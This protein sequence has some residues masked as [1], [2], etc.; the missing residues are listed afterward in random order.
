[1]EPGVGGLWWL[2]GSFRLGNL[3]AQGEAMTISASL[4]LYSLYRLLHT[5]K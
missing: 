1:V 2:W 4:N 5:C 3:A